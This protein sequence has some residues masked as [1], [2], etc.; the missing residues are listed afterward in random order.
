VSES[1]R[2]ILRNEGLDS[3]IEVLPLIMEIKDIQIQSESRHGIIFVGGFG[4][5]PNIDAVKYFV[6]EVMPLIREKLK[7][8]KFY[9][10]GTDPPP[11]IRLLACNDIIVMG[12]VQ[13]L[14]K[15]LA[16]VK[17]SV[18][19]LRFGAGVKG[20]V[21]TSLANGV[22]VVATPIA[23]EGMNLHDQVNV[24][25]AGDAHNFANSIINLFED[26]ELWNK[27]S[28]NGLA[29]VDAELG[30]D[31]ALTIIKGI[32]DSLGIGYEDKKYEIKLFS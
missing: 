11:E 18:A 1:E 21:A 29:L 28:S 22:P 12:Y 9:I 23:I 19:P 3:F 26:Q 13:D 5:S 2:E 32:F 16:S 25:I 10:V 4:H 8:I 17:V 14:N 30:P 27:L 7:G 6:S 24:L 31:R 20:K 15:L